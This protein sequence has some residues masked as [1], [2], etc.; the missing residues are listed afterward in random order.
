VCEDIEREIAEGNTQR[1][2]LHPISLRTREC[3]VV[4]LCRPGVPYLVE[5]MQNPE[6]SGKSHG[7]AVVRLPVGTPIPQFAKALSA[8]LTLEAGND[9]TIGLRIADI[10]ISIDPGIG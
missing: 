2:L 10:E 3:G 4:W 5:L 8:N 9:P 7:K 6:E 1:L